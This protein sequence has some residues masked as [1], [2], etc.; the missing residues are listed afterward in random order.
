MP[1]PCTG[2]Q[3]SILTLVN[4][5]FHRVKFDSGSFG[6]VGKPGCLKHHERSVTHYIVTCVRDSDD[7]GV[8]FV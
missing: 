4:A 3:K 8:G 7:S 5:G 2:I 1:R 6:I